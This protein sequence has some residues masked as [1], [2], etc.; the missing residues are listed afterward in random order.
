MQNSTS[1]VPCGNQPPTETSLSPTLLTLRFL[2]CPHCPC[3]NSRVIN[4]NKISVQWL[5]HQ[6][7]SGAVGSTDFNSLSR[8]SHLVVKN[9]SIPSY[10]IYHI[11]CIICH[12]SYIIYFI[13]HIS[14]IMYRVST[15]NIYHMF[16]MSYVKRLCARFWECFYILRRCIN[17]C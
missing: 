5:M 9:A 12:I 10:I 8:V 3:G 14:Y 13:C 16:H 6:S 15:Y 1:H 17:F 4:N 11:S 7:P 2:G